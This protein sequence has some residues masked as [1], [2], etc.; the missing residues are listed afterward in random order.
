MAAK[1][2]LL[3]GEASGDLHGANL[4]QAMYRRDPEIIIDGWGGPKMEAAGVNLHR[5]LDKLAFMGFVEI[6][7]N[8]GTVMESFRSIKRLLLRIR[9]DAIVLIDYP[10]F[11]LKLAKWAH[12][13]GFRVFYFISPT[14]W[15]WKQK[16]VFTIRDYTDHLY[17]IL[18]FEPAFY[19]RF[20]I[21]TTYVGNPLIDNVA[22][23]TPDP[24]FLNVHKLTDKG[25][26]AMLPG[27]RYQELHRILPVMAEAAAMLSDTQFVI[28]HTTL[29]PLTLYEKILDTHHPA[30]RDHIYIIADATYDV[31]YHAKAAM[32][33]SGTA[34][35]ETALFRIP[36]VVCYKTSSVN[37]TIA[38]YFV[39]LNHISLINIIAQEEIVS[40][41]IQD[42][43]TPQLLVTEIKRITEDDTQRAYIQGAYNRQIAS[44]GGPGV[45]ERLASHLLAQLNGGKQD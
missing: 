9:P 26:T 30:W 4:A 34:T 11:N 1:W 37:Y 27:S 14:V 7:R 18:P 23:F 5:R 29:L 40:E 2:F 38:R 44:L 28:A 20:G 33:T 25:Y 35:L 17:C 15:A 10:G 43:L 39:K 19:A 13:K 22:A 36:Q 41:L 12:Q 24:D 3:A 21:D 31:L 45:S 42:K 32:V 16:R 6:I 8:I